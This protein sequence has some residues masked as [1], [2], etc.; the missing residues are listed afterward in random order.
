MSDE[1]ICLELAQA[2][3]ADRARPQA[4]G[5]L[6]GLLEEAYTGLFMAIVLRIG[7]R[8]CQQGLRAAHRAA[9]VVS[10]VEYCR[11]ARQP[12]GTR[13]MGRALAT[14]LRGCAR[15]GASPMPPAHS[16]QPHRGTSGSLAWPSTKLGSIA[17]RQRAQQAR[18][19]HCA[20]APSCGETR[21]RGYCRPGRDGCRRYERR[22]GSPRAR[23]THGRRD[24]WQARRYRAHT[25]SPW[26]ANVQKHLDSPGLRDATRFS[27]VT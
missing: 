26:F 15:R 14:H 19:D 17:W 1:A 20:A 12:T 3:L 24:R 7:C 4:P 2:P 8:E 10:G 13:R 6:P 23:R 5:G 11:K 18:Q 25:R 21:L 16:R 22:G 9:F 27:R